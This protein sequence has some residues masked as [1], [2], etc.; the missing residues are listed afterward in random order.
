[1]RC[2][3]LWLVIFGGLISGINAQKVAV[4]RFDKTLEEESRILPKLKVLG[5]LGTFKKKPFLNSKCKT[6]G[7]SF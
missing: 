3:F 6:H 2:F 7:L 4:Y 5:Q 1:M